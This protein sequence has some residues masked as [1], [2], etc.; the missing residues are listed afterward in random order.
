MLRSCVFTFCQFSRDN[1]LVYVFRKL[2]TSIKNLLDPS[3]WV[4]VDLSPDYKL[5]KMF[6]N[7][8][9]IFNIHGIEKKRF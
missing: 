2:L 4:R 1:Q 3:I 9:V 5:L 8:K 7:D 6:K